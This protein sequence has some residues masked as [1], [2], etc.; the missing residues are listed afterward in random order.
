MPQRIVISRLDRIGD[1]II[2]TACLPE[3]RRRFPQAEIFFLVRTFLVPLVE[4]INC[5]DA[6][7]NYSEN[8]DKRA[9]IADLAERLKVE[10]IDI[11]IH[12]EP[13]LEAEEAGWLAGVPMRIGFQKNRREWL[14][15]RFPYRKKK[16]EKHESLYSFDLLG[17]IGVEVPKEAM[18]PCVTLV[19]SSR[20]SY[21]N[22]LPLPLK[23][24]QSYAV[25][26]PGAYA[27]KP[28]VPV[29]YYVAVAKALA[30]RGLSLVMTG[31]VVGDADCEQ[32]KKILS[33]QLINVYD[34][35]GQLTLSEL[36]H[37]LAQADV[38]FSRDTGPAHLSAAL[39]CPTVVFF[40]QPVPAF[41]GSIRWKPMGKHVT[42]IEKWI[43]EFPFE[44]RASIVRR[45]LNKITEIEVV[46]KVLNCNR[47]LDY[48]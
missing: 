20:D 33:E 46:E 38:F 18:I 36:S 5:V 34:L 2:S 19:E 3:V 40:V 15:H 37:C 45:H 28:R 21:F 7:W 24:G 6:V 27:G 14:T 42:V 16:G 31:D 25:I 11:L 47:S 43:R 13:H 35:S 30:E 48:T 17:A 9:R 44:S 29:R 41:A 23:N 10:K 39:G 26:H 12:L 32:I 1:V 4:G 22:K 8:E